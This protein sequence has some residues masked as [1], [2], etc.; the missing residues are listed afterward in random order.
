MKKIAV[1]KCHGGYSF[2]LKAHK[3]Y[4]DIIWKPIY[5]FTKV[6][7]ENWISYIEVD[8]NCKDNFVWCYSVPLDKVLEIHEEQ[9]NWRNLTD[10]QKKESNKKYSDASYDLSDLPRDDEIIIKIIETLWDE[11]SSRFSKIKIVE[12]PDDIEWEIS[13]Y[14]WYET[15]CEKHRKR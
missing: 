7:N 2:S 13:E 11:A 6:Y 1:N 3:M 5:F 10:E 15:L 8:E 9:S 14:D 12:I 4:A